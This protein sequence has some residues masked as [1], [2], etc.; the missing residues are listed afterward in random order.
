M[1]NELNEGDDVGL[2][3]RGLV[4]FAVLAVFFPDFALVGT[5]D[6]LAVV[7]TL[8]GA[9]DGLAVVGATVAGSGVGGVVACCFF[10]ST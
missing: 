8:V 10:D 2:A 4:G 3:V 5:L 9:K 7:G 1:G 6:G